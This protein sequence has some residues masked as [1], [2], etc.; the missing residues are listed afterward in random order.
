M[1]RF[2]VDPLSVT[3]A[4]LGDVLGADVR[5]CRLEQIG[6]GV[7]LLGRLY[8]AH[9]D[10][11]PDV[12][13][14]VVVKL[15]LAR[16]DARSA[17]CEDLEFY[18]REVRF[19]QEIGLANPLRPARPYFAAYDETTH[20][21][22]LVLEDLGLLRNADQI[23]GCTVADA[24]TVIDAIA[25][26]H[27]HWWESRRF[28]ALPWLQ[29]FST[30]PITAGLTANLEAAWP[31]FLEGVGTGLSPAMRAFGER[32]PALVPWFW[33]E[34]ARPPHTFLHGDLRLDQLFFAVKPDD[35]PLTALD[36]QVT[37]RGRSAYDVAYFVSQS[38]A[39]ETRRSCE[40]RLVE[41][42]AERLAE[43]G[44]DYPRDE[45]WRDYRLT[46]AWCFAYPV[47]AAGRIDLANDRQL[48]LLRSITDRAAVAIEDHDALSLRPD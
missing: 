29:P 21:F 11:G 13:R 43:H 33:Q 27:A 17:V 5:G 28:A 45:L 9:L 25:G 35:P 7:G 34:L 20:D 1:A 38:L 36:W 15:P 6:I 42:Y 31:R 3:G 10:G 14:S 2:P 24:E 30:P 48:H 12:P 41:R 16:S 22:V 39:T 47:I 40:S 23:A 44:I 26:H 18:L 46:T 8:R 32:I 4:W 19:Y 37:S